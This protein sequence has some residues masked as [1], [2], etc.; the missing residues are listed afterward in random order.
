M[1]GPAR[2]ALAVE[3]GTANTVPGGLEL[4]TD[5]GPQY[6]GSDCVTLRDDWGLDQPFAPVGRPTGNSVA[7][8]VIRALE[9]ECVWLEDWDSIEHLQAAIDAWK[10][11]YDH[12]R[13]H[14]ALDGQPPAERRHERLGDQRLAA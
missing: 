12:S 1:L 8:R 5:H 13:P 14:Q 2:R 7:E 6:T 9:E 11:Q 10:R 4:R 3:L